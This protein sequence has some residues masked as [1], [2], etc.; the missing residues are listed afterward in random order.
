[1]LLN[2]VNE[3]PRTTLNLEREGGPRP[4]W[5]DVRPTSL[6]F[7][8]RLIESKSCLIR[9]GCAGTG[10]PG[11]SDHAWANEADRESRWSSG[12]RLILTTRRARLRIA[13]L[14]ISL[15]NGSSNFSMQSSGDR[16][17]FYTV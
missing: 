13:D 1:M 17:P 4:A 9:C 16:R 2:D 11:W 6:P 5:A 8:H 14:S 15:S 3:L 12:H 7:G 10:F